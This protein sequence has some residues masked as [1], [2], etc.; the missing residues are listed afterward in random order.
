VNCDASG[1][2]TLGRTRRQRSSSIGIIALLGFVAA[3]LATSGAAGAG[4]PVQCGGRD[5]TIVGTP[6]DDIIYG[7]PGDDV[8][9]AL[10]GNDIV[11]GKQGN[12][13]LCGSHGNDRLYGGDGSDKLYAFNGADHLQGGNGYDVL[14]GGR[15]PDMLLGGNGQ[16]TLKG[17][18]GVDTLKGGPQRDALRGGLHIDQLF[19]GTELDTC[20]SPGDVLNECE[21]GGGAIAGPSITTQYANEML[22]LINTE[23]AATS[24]LDPLARHP[25]LDS[26]ARAW[27]QEMSTEPLPLT[28]YKHHSPAFTGSNHPFQPLPSSVQWTTAFENVGYSTVGTNETVQ[29]VMNRLFY[30]PNGYGFM[31]SAGHK[32]NILETAANEVGLGAYVDSVGQVWVVQVFW[33]T[34]YPL[35]S[36]VAQCASVV[37]R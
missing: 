5:A 26:Y 9:A 33:G 25:D 11:Y 21:R 6:G 13:R 4:T 35:P 32:C 15:G 37:N 28:S 16:D 14:Y 36:P 8:I 3:L 17:G 23:R 19:G 22:R 29:S 12:D 2:E 10:G 30:S 31:S 34:D 27:A 20:Y 18:P 7:T 24:V 1:D